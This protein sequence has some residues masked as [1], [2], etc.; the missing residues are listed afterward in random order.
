M[1]HPPLFIRILL[2]ESP[3]KPDSGTRS[4]AFCFAVRYLTQSS[5]T[6][7]PDFTNYY[8]FFR[9]HKRVYIG[10]YQPSTIAM[11]AEL[12]FRITTKIRRLGFMKTCTRS[13]AGILL[14]GLV[15]VT[16]ITGIV[17][18]RQNKE[19][20]MITGRST[21]YCGQVAALHYYAPFGIHR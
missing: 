2:P 12:L 17:R 3:A 6:S 15:V 21:G 10:H 19:C 20:K 4:A 8:H 1:R 16:V 5:H 18:V 9:I 11:L 7:N 13:L 14:T